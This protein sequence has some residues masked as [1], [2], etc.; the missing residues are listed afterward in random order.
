MFL[1]KEISLFLKRI[2]SYRRKD[3]SRIFKAK[4][5]TYFSVHNDYASLKIGEAAGAFDWKS[6][7][8]NSLKNTRSF[9]ENRSC[10]A[11]LP[12]LFPVP[13]QG[14]IE[15]KPCRA[16]NSKDGNLFDRNVR[17]SAD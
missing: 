11:C 1:C 14:Q 16:V 5:H 3:F 17:A 4:L 15:Q 7:V 6:P 10:S 9:V 12:L 13:G 2:E 8:L